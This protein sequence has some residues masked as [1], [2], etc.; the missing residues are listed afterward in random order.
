M[1]MGPLMIEIQMSQSVFVIK[2]CYVVVVY[3]V[4]V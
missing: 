3:V 4:M 2:H 1:W